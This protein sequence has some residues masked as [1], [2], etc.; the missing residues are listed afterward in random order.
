MIRFAT[1]KRYR[2]RVCI[3]GG[4]FSGDSVRTSG[5]MTVLSALEASHAR[6][7]TAELWVYCAES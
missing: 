5:K 3:S 7:P 2:G 1:S 6:L 4:Y